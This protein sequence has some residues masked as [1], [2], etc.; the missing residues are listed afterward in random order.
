MTTPV[1][2]KRKLPRFHITPCQFH[3]QEMAK[4]FSVLDISEGGLSLRLVDRNDLPEFSVGVERTGKIKV[5]GMKLPCVFKVRHLRGILIGAEWVNPTAELLEHLSQLSHPQHLGEQ[6]R[7][8][9]LPEIVNTVW[10]HNPVGVDLLFYRN[11]ETNAVS[12]WTLYVHQ[13]FVQWD[14]ESGMQTGQALAEDDEGSVHGL[15][16]L[17]TRLIEYDLRPD[18]RFIEMALELIQNAPIQETELKTMI[19]NHLKGVLG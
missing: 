12:R 7:S 13:S 1:T 11:Q 4:S 14:M 9:E 3:D 2:E 19:V 18:Q 16:R 17:E 5:E 8:Y 15:V 10:Y 6:L